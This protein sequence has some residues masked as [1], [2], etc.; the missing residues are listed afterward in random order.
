L[1]VGQTNQVK[2]KTKMERKKK[3]IG[4]KGAEEEKSPLPQ[5]KL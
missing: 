1:Q 4:K 5:K 2:P 3:I